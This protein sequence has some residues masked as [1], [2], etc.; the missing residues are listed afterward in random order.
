M[1]T[2]PG[3]R[4]I[5]GKI[6]PPAKKAATESLFDTSW[7]ELASAMTTIQQQKANTLSFEEVYRLG[8]N[9]VIHKYGEKLYLGIQDL[10][11][12]HLKTEA[13][14]KIVPVLGIADASPAE[15]VELLK[16]IQRVWMHHITCMKMIKDIL[17]HLDKNYVPQTRLPTIYDMGLYIFRDS[18][19]RSSTHPIQ[20]HLQLVLLNQITQERKGDVIDRGAVKASTDMLLEMKENN[21]TEAVYITDFEVLFVETSREFYRLE[22]EDLVRRFDPPD[23]MKKVENR[24][25]EEK[26]RCNHYLTARTE[27]KIRL[28]VEQEMIAK[29]LKTIMEMENWGL[30]QLL[31]NHRLEDLD[32]MY[33]LFSRVPD[34]ANELQNGVAAYINECGKA[35]NAGVKA[36]TQ[37]SQ[38]KGA[39]P[40]VTVALRWVQEVLDL[41]DKFDKVLALS[42]AKDKSFETAINAAFERFINLNI[43]APEFM[44]L[45]ID[46]K[47]KKEFKG[48]SDDEVDTILNKMTTLF[49]FLSD[50]DVFERY[51]KQHLSTR[52]LLGKSISDEVERGMI[53]KLKIECGYQFTSKLEGMFTDMRLLPDTMSSFKDFLDHAIE[54]NV[55]LRATFDSKKHELNVST[56]AAVVLLVFN[57]IPANESVSY[58]AIRE[59]TKLP[60]EHLKRTLQ[61]VA[62]GKFKILIKEPKSREIEDTDQFT[63]NAGFSE[64][65][66][67]IKIQTVASKV[68]T[69]AE[70]KETKEKVDDARNHMAE[71]AIVRVMKNRKQLD[72]NNLVA[73]VVAQLQ[74]RFNP[75]PTM[76]KRR[77]EALIEREYLERAPGDRKLYNYMA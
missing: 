27:P 53:T 36:S 62:C 34:G 20:A 5:R 35:S 11:D 24:L 66:T 64:K 10:I 45:F 42:F 60:D 13:E 4:P 3:R 39:V 65:L 51:Y 71:A 48:K 52:L 15:G 63:F 54:G 67:R 77:I 9:M 28:I 25:D 33:R 8:Y 17:V 31:I 75:S 23:Y 47:L 58:T 38:E 21:G 18:I 44:S 32:R 7:P 2:L 56:M 14:A 68:E 73:E 41:K 6:R 22:S 26:L 49:R 57:N 74:V 59:E 16:A 46:N 50:K 55:D 43:K 69:V 70:L 76:I 19:I 40:G 72:H 29:H 12:K 30:K 37:E 1:A 61:S